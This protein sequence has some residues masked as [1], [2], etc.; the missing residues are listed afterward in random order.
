M[1]NIF[2]RIFSMIV[3]FP[4]YLPQTRMIDRLDRSNCPPSE[5]RTIRIQG[6]A[7]FLVKIKGASHI[8]IN[9]DLNAS[10]PIA[11]SDIK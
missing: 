3:F 6:M 4:L 2:L 5:G 7:R 1:E 11:I 9:G 8:Y 10:S